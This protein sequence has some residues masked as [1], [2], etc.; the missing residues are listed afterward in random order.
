MTPSRIERK[1]ETRG[2]VWNCC[3]ISGNYGKQLDC[4]DKLFLEVKKDFPDLKRSDVECLQAGGCRVRYC[5]MLRF[6][7]PLGSPIPAGWYAS[8]H[9]EELRP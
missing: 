5:A 4:Y 8:N 1:V 2:H 3:I 9:V 7:I 6:Q